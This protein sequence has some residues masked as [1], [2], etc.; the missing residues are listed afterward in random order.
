MSLLHWAFTSWHWAWTAFW[1][2]VG[3][4]FLWAMLTPD[5]FG[6]KDK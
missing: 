2:L 1:V 6:W 5:W 4:G 3:V